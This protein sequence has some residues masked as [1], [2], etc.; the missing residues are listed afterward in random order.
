MDRVG[1]PKIKGDAS[2]KLL[3]IVCTT[4]YPYLEKSINSDFGVLLVYKVRI[5]A[6]IY[7][8]GFSNHFIKS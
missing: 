5:F 3:R 1:R 8:S 7:S 2:V 6:G 4:V